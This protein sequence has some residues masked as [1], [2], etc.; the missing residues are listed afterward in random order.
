MVSASATDAVV[1]RIAI[2]CAGEPA[3]WRKGGTE[4]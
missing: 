1:G 2:G 4:P 3:C